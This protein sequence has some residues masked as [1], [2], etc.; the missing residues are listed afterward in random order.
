MPAPRGE[1]GE[2]HKPEALAVQGPPR[3]PSLGTC[4]SRTTHCCHRRVPARCLRSQPSEGGSCSARG[5]CGAGGHP[6]CRPAHPWGS[7]PSVQPQREAGPPLSSDEGGG[8]QGWGWRVPASQGSWGWGQTMWQ[9]PQFVPCPLTTLHI[10]KPHPAPPP[11]SPPPSIPAAPQHPKSPQRAPSKR[12][13]ISHPELHALSRTRRR[14]AGARGC[15]RG[16]TP[17]WP[18]SPRSRCRSPARR[19][20][21]PAGAAGGAEW[22]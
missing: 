18:P 2:R 10:S 7:C 11:C 8:S 5:C 21:A 1:L 9:P 16:G 14:G 12:P 20:E 6:Q 19:C 4:P 15:A 17:C 22:C 3:C 13:R